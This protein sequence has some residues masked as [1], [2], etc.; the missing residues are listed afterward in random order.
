[1]R[2]KEVELNQKQLAQREH[3][4]SLMRRRKELD[5][6]E[7]ELLVRE[8]Q[9]MMTTQ[10]APTPKKRLGKFSKAKLKVMWN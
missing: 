4:E 1:M 5:A 7:M 3:E 2:C 6:R 10:A 8:L 9:I